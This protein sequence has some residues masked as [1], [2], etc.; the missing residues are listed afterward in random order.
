MTRIE[1]AAAIVAEYE[2]YNR[3]P[4]FR[5]GI[6]RCEAANPYAPDSVEA[7][8]FDRGAEAALRIRRLPQEG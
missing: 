1:N 5:R 3:L 4:A 8:A 6:G 7:Q 2:P